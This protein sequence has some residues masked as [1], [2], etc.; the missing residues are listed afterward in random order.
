MTE[1]NSNAYPTLPTERETPQQAALAEWF[2][3][4]HVQ[5][6]AN[7]ETAA[8]QIITLCTTLLGVL[9]GLMALTE[10]TLPAYMQWS[11]I[12]WLSG[13]GVVGLFAALGCGLYVVIPRP[14]MVTIN[15]PDNMGAEFTAL[16]ARKSRGL[17]L[18]VIL[19]GAA[20]FCLVCVIIISLAL[21][22][23]SYS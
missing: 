7:L 2:A 21:V 5:S 23:G 9:L 1:I 19:F 15:D 12:Q 3:Q 10:D 20:M 14:N 22:T 4:Q 13:L 6:A 8:R 18:A 11:G 17:L 16:L